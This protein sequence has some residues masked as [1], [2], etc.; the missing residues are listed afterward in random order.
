[1]E[2][3]SEAH[4]RRT[5]S[6]ADCIGLQAAGSPRQSDRRGATRCS[7]DGLTDK[8]LQD[9]RD[10]LSESNDRLQQIGPQ[11]RCLAQRCLLCSQQVRYAVRIKPHWQGQ[12]HAAWRVCQHSAQSESASLVAVFARPCLFCGSQAKDSRAHASQCPAL[13]QF[14]AGRCLVRQGHTLQEAAH[15]N[16][17]PSAVAAK[18]EPQHR[19][20]ADLFQRARPA[21]LALAPA[22]TRSRSKHRGFCV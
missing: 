16:F 10:L 15:A 12:H 3:S 14:L 13:F 11:L 2:F 18:S 4:R 7:I 9:A 17:C 8:E 6:D 19:P 20:I 21:Q 5:L 1:M 22:S